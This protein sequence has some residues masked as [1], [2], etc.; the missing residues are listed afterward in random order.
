MKEIKSETKDAILPLMAHQN[1]KFSDDYACWYDKN[2]LVKMA[3][4]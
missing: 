2:L 4:L 3:N 1:L